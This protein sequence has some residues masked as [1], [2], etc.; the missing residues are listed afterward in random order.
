MVATEIEFSEVEVPSTLAV[1]VPGRSGPSPASIG[2]AIQTAFETLHGLISQHPLAPAGPPRVIYN[3][4]G[5]E[6]VSFTL[7]LPVAAPV[8]S[9]QLQ[10]LEG[11]KAFRFTH[12]GSHHNLMQT[13]GQIT[14]FMKSRGW[15]QT[16]A[17]WARYMPMWEEYLN[18]PAKTPE[19]EL[20]T[21]IYLPA[22]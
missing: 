17:D 8:P 14:A 7:A 21:Y 18:D 15:M 2:A 16:D 4:Y 6:G 1:Q 12:H 11:T 13:Y 22:R 19:A 5:A 3:S 10:P 20:L 9:L